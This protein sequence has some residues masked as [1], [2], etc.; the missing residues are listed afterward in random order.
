MLD[1]LML[2]TLQS[3]AGMSLCISFDQY[4]VE[5]QTDNLNQ[6]RL[7]RDR[8]LEANAGLSAPILGLGTTMPV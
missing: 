2:T 3:L 6:P 8:C 1:D 7:S 5:R 4:H